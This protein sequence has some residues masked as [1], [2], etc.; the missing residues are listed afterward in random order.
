MSQQHLE[1]YVGTKCVGC[2]SC[3]AECPHAA[4]T[5]ETFGALIQP[6]IDKSKC[7]EC[8]LCIKNC[9]VFRNMYLEPIKPDISRIIGRPLKAYIGFASNT[10]IRT[11]GSSGGVATALLKYLLD[12][13]IIN[14]VVTAHQKKLIAQP[15]II[16]ESRDLFEVQG[17]IYFP[18]F[19][20]KAAKEI[21]SNQGKYAV[22]GLP[23]QIDSLRRIEATC[24]KL[25]ERIHVHIGLFCSHTNEYW[26]LKYL[27]SRYK[28]VRCDP[29]AVSS[30]H[31][32][33]PGSIDLET[34]CGSVTIPHPE[35]WGTIPL[36][37][38]SSPTGCLFC[39]NHMNIHSDIALGTLRVSIPKV[40][41]EDDVGTST[42]IAYTKRGS[43]IIEDAK[44]KGDISLKEINLRTL[45]E[46]QQ[47]SIVAKY[48]GV[49][50]RRSIVRRRCVTEILSKYTVNKVLISLLPLINS[51]LGHRSELRRM[52]YKY[53]IF[54]KILA[55]YQILMQKMLLKATPTIMRA[56]T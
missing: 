35:F 1:T 29:L 23:C 17:S 32:A 41:D 22:V 49:P 25:R 9:P 56:H 48:A 13:E 47:G 28:G 18:S 43:T 24:K 34:L 27:S 31:G 19:I 50:L 37:H 33:W 38:F 15:V 39:D 6:I 4:V 20:T 10:L 44:K 3:I 51:Y 52:L 16:N 54:E 5:V 21:L 53:R 14:Y 42:V 12:E 46:S 45:I 30:R 8:D 55:Q 26:Y 40:T 36:L 2:G 7:S 11:N